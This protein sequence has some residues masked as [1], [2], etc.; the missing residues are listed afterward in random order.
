MRLLSDDKWV[1]KGRE[2]KNPEKSEKR[3]VSCVCQPLQAED[4]YGGSENELL[5][6]S[7]LM[8]EVS[9]AWP[10]WKS[11]EYVLTVHEIY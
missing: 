1:R 2:V 7:T 9:K 8:V 11:S 4:G 3:L 6:E 5:C 10:E